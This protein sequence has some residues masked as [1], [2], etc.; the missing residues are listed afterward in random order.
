MLPSNI[1][2]YLYK[3]FMNTFIEKTMNV[4][5][6]MSCSGSPPIPGG[7]APNLGGAAQAP[8]VVRDIRIVIDPN[9]NLKNN[10][11]R[12]I[13][14]S[15]AFGFDQNKNV[16][17]D[18]ESVCWI[19]YSQKNL[20][21]ILKNFNSNGHSIPLS[22]VILDPL[23]NFEIK[24]LFVFQ[25]FA[26]FVSK[27]KFDELF[28]F[29]YFFVLADAFGLDALCCDGDVEYDLEMFLI[30]VSSMVNRDNV[31][32]AYVMISLIIMLSQQKK[33][34]FE[35]VRSF[36]LIQKEVCHNN[37]AFMTKSLMGI[38]CVKG[39]VIEGDFRR[40]FE[41]LIY[42]AD[43][44]EGFLDSLSFSKV[45]FPIISEE[46]VNS[47]HFSTQ[48]IEENIR[49]V[50]GVDKNCNHSIETRMKMI[51]PDNFE[52]S[53]PLMDDKNVCPEPVTDEQ[54]LEYDYY[55]D[56]EELEEEEQVEEEEDL[57]HDLEKCFIDLCTTMRCVIKTQLN[58]KKKIVNYEFKVHKVFVKKIETE[59]IVDPINFL[60][61]NHFSFVEPFV[62]N[63]KSLSN[64]PIAFDDEDVSIDKWWDAGCNSDEIS[65][66]LE[67]KRKNY[68][69][70]AYRYNLVV[71]KFQ[72]K[73]IQ[74][75]I[76]FI[77]S[78]INSRPQNES[79]KI[80]NIDRF[81]TKLKEDD[82]FDELEDEINE[83]FEF[84]KMFSEMTKLKLNL[85]QTDNLFELHRDNLILIRFFKNNLVVKEMD[86]I[87][88]LGAV[89]S[90]DDFCAD[91][92]MKHYIWDNLLNVEKLADAKIIYVWIP[93]RRRFVNLNRF[94]SSVE[95][96]KRIY[97]IAVNEEKRKEVIAR[98]NSKIKG[99]IADSEYKMLVDMVYNRFEKRL[100]FGEVRNV[101]KKIIWKLAVEEVEKINVLWK[102]INLQVLMYYR[103]GSSLRNKKTNYML[104]MKSETIL[105]LFWRENFPNYNFS[106]FTRFVDWSIFDKF[107]IYNI[108]W[109]NDAVSKTS[110][111]HDELWDKLVN[112]RVK[113]IL[114]AKPSTRS[115]KL[116]YFRELKDKLGPKL[117]LKFVDLMIRNDDNKFIF[118]F[119]KEN[120]LENV[121]SLFRIYSD[122]H[123]SQFQVSEFSDEAIQLINNFKWR[124]VNKRTVLKKFKSF[125]SPIVK[126]V[127]FNDVISIDEE[128]CNDF[129]LNKEVMCR[130]VV[131]SNHVFD[132]KIDVTKPRVDVVELFDVFTKRCMKGLHCVMKNLFMKKEE[133]IFVWKNLVQSL[134]QR[135]QSRLKH[136][137]INRNH[138]RLNQMVEKSED[139]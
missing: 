44:K 88:S 125:C 42:F 53:V 57:E 112:L 22:L 49:E 105:N 102:P 4:Y 93:V 139:V 43:R 84:D 107:Q 136:V 32:F 82:L 29:F 86:K 81:I 13:F 3:V 19:Y 101:I 70:F 7:P 132:F 100:N 38:L 110:I 94:E 59:R 128:F 78:S 1:Q 129:I 90:N 40:A 36:N 34:L 64:D 68:F 85:V 109:N 21:H 62:L 106:M 2:G 91:S 14:V 31:K 74:W 35:V 133:F 46:A 45:D 51:I 50:S 114:K 77:N 138:D 87:V 95:K 26:G 52:V 6:T 41:R 15:G 104:N 97:G 47:D 18:S 56:E 28:T 116:R 71:G 108:F 130:P 117:A 58:V 12:S 118:D 65:L 111:C 48:K 61:K 5:P 124:L 73:T 115:L 10:L 137:K 134:E 9:K 89:S 92:K 20:N 126:K 131:E 135:V 8:K 113:F 55:Y 103:F 75:K 60:K 98:I 33:V 96:S 99:E 23:V 11:V 119:Q 39:V 72:H 79:V 127:L 120:E 83:Y 37:H 122:L 17:I 30:G 54:D 80:E 76:S 16:L 69:S 63:A 121:N 24:N 67:K 123:C 27:L 66:K 25:F